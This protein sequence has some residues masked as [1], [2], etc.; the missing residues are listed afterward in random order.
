MKKICMMM[1][2]LAVI[3]V[4][5]GQITEEKIQGADENT[6]EMYLSY[7]YTDEAGRELTFE[8]KPVRIATSYLPLWES[9]ILL[10]ITPVGASNA[11]N[12]M[13]T[14]D[15]LQ[16][17]DLGDV[18]D[19]GSK[20]INLELLV[21]LDP[22]LF[23]EQVWDIST[24]DIENLEKVSTVA[25]FGPATKFDWRMNLRQVAQVVNEKEKAEQII[26]E[27]EEKLA[28]SRDKLK[29][30]ADGKTV[31][32]MSLMSIDRFF[33]TYRE[34]LY[35]AENGLG[36]IPPEGFTKNKSY[37]Q[38]SMEALVS[39]NPD[40]IFIN[41]FDGDEAMYEEFQQNPVWQTLSAVKNDKVYRLDGS[42]HALSGLSTIYTIDKI[43]EILIQE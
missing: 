19:L 43:V 7:T 9:L 42:G 12:Y 38:I 13:A 35:D 24:Y 26:K 3:C 16:D 30:I 5:C 41:V 31:M 2:A 39:M 29:T 8:K 37:D 18:A 17:K 4:G 40:I 32:Q 10:D 6:Q 33:M 14:W 22:D 15:A 27:V 36:L 34:E 25:L 1:I 20:E 21:S 11:E 23:L 28:S